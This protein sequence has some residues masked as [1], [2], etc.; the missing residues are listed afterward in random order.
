VKK[1]PCKDCE[2]RAPGCHSNCE[3]YKAF[4]EKWEAEKR[5]LRKENEYV[6]TSD[7]RY[8]FSV[9][10]KAWFIPKKRRKRRP[11]E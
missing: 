6:V 3:G 11:A 2:K 4:Q 10:A 9:T 8:R 1:P 5:W 7:T